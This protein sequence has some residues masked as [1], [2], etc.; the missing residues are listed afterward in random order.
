MGTML[1]PH[2]LQI[3]LVLPLGAGVPAG[4][5][6]AQHSNTA[7]PSATKAAPPKAEEADLGSNL[8]AWAVST[9]STLGVP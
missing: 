9:V 4:A 1:R 6:L 7:G 2:P 5:S 3:S 8:G